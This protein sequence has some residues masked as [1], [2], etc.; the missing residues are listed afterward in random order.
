MTYVYCPRRSNGAFELVKALGADR[1]R[2]FD[3]IDFWDRQKRYALKEGDVVICWGATIPE[4]DGIRVLNSVEQPFTGIAEWQKLMNFGVPV[5]TIGRG[6]SAPGLLVP[7]NQRVI[8][9]VDPTFYIQREPFV[10]EYRIHSFAGRSIR[11]GVKVSREGF[12]TCLESEWRPDAKL[13]HPWIRS[14]EGG[15]CVN[16]DGFKSTPELRR[17]AHKAVAGLGLT[18]GAVDIGQRADKVLK[19]LEVDRAP[20]I[21]GGTINSYVR[22]INRWIK[23]SDVVN[24]GKGVD[25]DAGGIPIGTPVQAIEDADGDDPDTDPGDL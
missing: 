16:Y 24:A 6:K 2:K 11:A 13:V 20:R 25:D 3:G 21:E 17:L 9:V 8:Q 7:R 22:A 15:W 10:N 12:T 18:F 5:L 14:H 1:L 4:L 23:E 19:V